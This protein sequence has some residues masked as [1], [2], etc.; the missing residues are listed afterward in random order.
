MQQTDW[1]RADAKALAVIADHGGVARID[2][3][4]K[5][6][7]TRHQIAAIFRRGVIE[8]PRNAWY[9]DPALPWRAKH[10]IRVGGVLACV[11]SAETHGLPVPPGA[12][13]LIHVQMPGNAPRARHH[14]NKSQYVVPGEDREVQRHWCVQDGSIPGWRTS[15]V[16]T[17]LLLADCVAEDWWIAA[18]DAALHVPRD[19]E[20]LLSADEYA[21]LES[22]LP[23]RLRPALR[24]VNPLAGSCIET[25]LRLGMERRGIGPLV[26]QFSPQKHRFVDFLL[27]GKL[28]IEADGEEFHDPEQDRIRDDMFRRLGYTVLRFPYERIVFDLERVLDEI[29]AAL[30]ALF[31][32]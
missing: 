1:S 21:T 22:R 14:R 27:P 4:T 8:R 24:R 28:I 30:E 12:H 29:E 6:G 10:A 20:P 3:L 25:L 11:S 31:I 26:L 32:V 9:V 15:L 5:A 17:L 7:L 23:A 18:M 19:G 2:D 16:D 13:L